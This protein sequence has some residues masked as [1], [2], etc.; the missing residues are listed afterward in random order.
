[1]RFNVRVQVVTSAL[2]AHTCECMHTCHRRT[3]MCMSVIRARL[4]KRKLLRSFVMR[5]SLAVPIHLCFV[6]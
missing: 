4:R 5:G 2:R 3:H 1:M 6:R